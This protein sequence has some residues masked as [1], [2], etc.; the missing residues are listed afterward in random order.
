MIALI[1]GPLFFAMLKDHF[2]F[3]RNRFYGDEA[4]KNKQ[5]KR[6]EAFDRM[7]HSYGRT[8][9]TYDVGGNDEGND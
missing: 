2:G 1:A 7:P 8:D 6:E 9:G 4:N 3:N 5:S